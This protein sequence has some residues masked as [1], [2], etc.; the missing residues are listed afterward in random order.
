M[1][2]RMWNIS[3]PVVLS[4][5]KTEIPRKLKITIRKPTASPNNL[6]CFKEL[7]WIQLLFHSS[8]WLTF[9]NVFHLLMPEIL[10]TM[11]VNSSICR[12]FK[13]LQ[14]YSLCW[15]PVFLPFPPTY[16]IRFQTP[17]DHKTNLVLSWYNGFLNVSLEICP[18]W[19]LFLQRFTSIFLNCSDSNFKIFHVFGHLAKLLFFSTPLWCIFSLKYFPYQ[20]KKI[21]FTVSFNLEWILQLRQFTQ[22]FF[23]NFFW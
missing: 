11:K 14:S 21:V 17:E 12:C 18:S 23:I 9:L 4:L 2:P 3:H 19:I 16:Q 13:S 22:I 5:V 7:S 15:I 6:K 1:K 20:I 8:V 10:S